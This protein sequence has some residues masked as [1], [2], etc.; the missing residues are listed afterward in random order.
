LYGG[1][2]GSR[3][4]FEPV[5]RIIDALAHALADR[6]SRLLRRPL[7]SLDDGQADNHEPHQ[8]GRNDPL[9]NTH[10]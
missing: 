7:L 8:G 9:K 5:D 4:L 10:G 1:L 3:A 6:H 2:G